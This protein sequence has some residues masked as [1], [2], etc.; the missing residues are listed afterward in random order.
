MPD[1]QEHTRKP[2]EGLS[3]P[4]RLRICS[5]CG[6]LFSDKTLMFDMIVTLQ[7]EVPDVLDLDAI[8]DAGNRIE[9]IEKIIDDLDN[10]DP[11]EIAAEIH[12]RHHYLV[13]PECRR[14][15]HQGLVAKTKKYGFAT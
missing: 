9:Q 13:C 12:E 3:Q 2:R 15:I 7:A 14:A 5:E 11:E 8:D 6:G 4:K 1:H 10:C